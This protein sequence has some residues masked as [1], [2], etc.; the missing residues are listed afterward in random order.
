M[1]A[2]Q[3][4]LTLVTGAGTTLARGNSQST[5][6]EIEGPFTAHPSVKVLDQADMRLFADFFLLLH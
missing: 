4:V 5:C 6:S 3:G 1:W 2:T